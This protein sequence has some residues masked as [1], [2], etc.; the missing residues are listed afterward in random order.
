MQIRKKDTVPSQE[1]RILRSLCMFSGCI[2]L[3]DFEAIHG[4]K[5]NTFREMANKGLIEM[6]DNLVQ[7]TD[8]GRKVCEGSDNGFF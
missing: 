3:S 6:G 5:I 7:I 1:L 4:L 8:E 2:P